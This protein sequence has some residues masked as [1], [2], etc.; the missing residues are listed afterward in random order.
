MNRTAALKVPRKPSLGGHRISAAAVADAAAYLGLNAPITIKW[1]QG[2]R[3][4]GA[5]R[6]R[7]GVGHVITVTTYHRYA[8]GVSETI[9]HELTH[10]RQVEQVNDPK[11]FYTAYRMESARVGYTLNRFEVEAREVGARMAVCRPLVASQVRAV[12]L[13]DPKPAAPTPQPVAGAVGT[14]QR[15]AVQR[16]NRNG[17]TVQVIDATLDPRYHGGLRWVVINLS[18][19]RVQRFAG[20]RDAKAAIAS[21]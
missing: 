15:I 6:F 12:P 19:G 18:T 14:G 1:S 20:K 4:L 7:P 5:H 16:T 8:H 9:W 3:R 11:D 13:P 17:H 2:R 21:A 10:A